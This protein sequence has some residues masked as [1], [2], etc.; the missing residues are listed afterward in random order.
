MTDRVALDMYKNSHKHDCLELMEADEVA[1]NALQERIDRE[2]GCEYCSDDYCPPLDWQ[3]G[4][5]HILPDYCFCPMCGR[6][7][8]TAMPGEEV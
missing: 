6:K 3:Y 4:L 5:D 7:I 1:Y 2:K 8:K